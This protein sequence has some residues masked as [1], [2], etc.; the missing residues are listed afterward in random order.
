[1]E[2]KSMFKNLINKLSGGDKESC[3]TGGYG[4]TIYEKE[5][6][7]SL[8]EKTGLDSKDVDKVLTE[9]QNT[10][11]EKVLDDGYTISLAK[12]GKFELTV[13][14]ARNGRNPHTGKAIKIPE[15][16]RVHFKPYENLKKK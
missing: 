16:R 13:R 15:S 8:A 10:V 4:D 2:I 7:D 6:I 12:F 9:F 3:Q 14:E 1:M 11:R 5:L